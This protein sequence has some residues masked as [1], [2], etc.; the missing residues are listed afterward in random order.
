M[1]SQP[2]S[3]TS[4]ANLP[5]PYLYSKRVDTAG[6][7]Y[8]E[9]HA[10]GTTT[11]LHPIKLAELQ[12]AGLVA[13]SL[14]SLPFTPKYTAD[15]LA[16]GEHDDSDT[17][18]GIDTEG[19][20]REAQERGRLGREGVEVRKIKGGEVDGVKLPETE[21]WTDKGEMPPWVVEE[22]TV[23]KEGSGE[24]PQ[25][26]WVDYRVDV[27]NDTQSPLHIAEARRRIKARKEREA[28]E[29]ARKAAEKH[30]E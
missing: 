20:R 14:S 13:P 12:S 18:A 27:M 10:T 30:G 11:W 26:Y 21:E 24:E 1:A 22:W 5:L 19:L 9:N 7:T 2:T 29:A 17:E 16:A 23:P 3:T 28:E 4:V 8:Y 6:R 25:P 15:E